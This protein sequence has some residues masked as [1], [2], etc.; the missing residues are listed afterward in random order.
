[1]GAM[2]GVCPLC[3]SESRL[4]ADGVCAYRGGCEHRQAQAEAMERRIDA[5]VARLGEI[6]GGVEQ[7]REA[8]IEGVAQAAHPYDADLIAY[9]QRAVA[10]HGAPV[11]VHCVALAN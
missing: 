7:L 9:H 6:V 2:T 4:G 1:M 10:A 11:C 8:M 3:G 5:G